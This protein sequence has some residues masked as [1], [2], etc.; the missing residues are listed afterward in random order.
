MKYD[1]IVGLK[2]QQEKENLEIIQRE[3]DAMLRRKE[4]ISITALAKYAGVDRSYFYRNLQAKQMV[5]D[6]Q[7]SRENVITLK[8]QF[9]IE[10]LRKLISS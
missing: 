3:I 4:R 5:E 10:R 9:L 6:A 1:K 2:K 7:L 8:R